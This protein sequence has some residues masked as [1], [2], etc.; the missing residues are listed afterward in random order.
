MIQYSH[1]MIRICGSCVVRGMTRIA[2][3]V[4]QLI[5]VVRVA[6]LALDRQVFPRQ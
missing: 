6:V 5:V 1:D 3:R 2:V 4:S